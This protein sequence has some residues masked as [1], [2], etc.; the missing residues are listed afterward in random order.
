[1]DGR[2][3]QN[4]LSPKFARQTRDNPFSPFISPLP[5]LFSFTFFLSFILLF[6]SLYPFLS[7]SLLLYVYISIYLFP[8]S[9]LYLIYNVFYF[10]SCLPFSL[11]FFLFLSLIHTIGYNGIDIIRKVVFTDTNYKENLPL[12]D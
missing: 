10:Y 2:W 5:S 12:K 4:N 8:F 11:L 1:M 3:Q 9:Q 7:N 6:F